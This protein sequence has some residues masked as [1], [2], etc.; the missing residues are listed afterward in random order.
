MVEYYGRTASHYNEWHLDPNDNSNH[1]RAVR[2]VLKLLAEAPGSK[3]LDVCC[4]TG[5][6]L[7][8]ALDAK[9]D[10]RGIDISPEMLQVAE[11]DLKIPRERLQC[12]DATRLPYPDNAFDFSCVLGALH[13]CA[14]PDAIVSEMARV[15][16]RT[17]V[18]SDEGN[19]LSNGVKSILIKLGLFNVVYRMIFR[20]APRVG[21][22]L[23]NS[24]EDGP[25]FDFTIEELLPRIKRDYK[26]VK[27]LTFYRIF[28][29]DVSAYWF[30][31]VFARQVV[32]I[33]T[34][35]RT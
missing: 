14:I 12:G 4:G 26:R 30:P 13:H 27:C 19:R 25:A 33:A 16:S 8:A 5:R 34:D 32:V 31:R 29:R 35:K 9:F 17:I 18:I 22:K 24:Q 1:N 6:C 21:R 2:V 23:V 7:R 10:A 28:G 20:R 3:L 11:Q 15:T